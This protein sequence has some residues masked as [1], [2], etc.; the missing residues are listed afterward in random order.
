MCLT[1]SGF[2]ILVIL[3]LLAHENPT[4]HTWF[5]IMNDLH[6]VVLGC[7]RESFFT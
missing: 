3:A 6:F 4:R 1:S 5:Q 7:R 2:N